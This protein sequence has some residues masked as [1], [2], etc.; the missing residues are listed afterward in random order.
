MLWQFLYH[1]QLYFLN[2]NDFHITRTI[3]IAIVTVIDIIIVV[4][5]ETFVFDIV[6]FWRKNVH[7]DGG[8]HQILIFYVIHPLVSHNMHYNI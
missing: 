6:C 1:Y 4:I 2:Y 8:E 5:S 7:P 3:I